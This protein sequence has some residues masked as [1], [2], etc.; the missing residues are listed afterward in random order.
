MKRS[1][2]VSSSR[3][4]SRKAHFTAP[5]SVRRK[6]MSAGLSSELRS[7]YNCRSLPIR[8]DDEVMIVRGLYKNREGKVITCYRKKY[9]IYVD[10][11]VREKATSAKVNVPIHPSNCVIMKL[12]LDKDRKALLERKDRSKEI[13]GKFT[14]EEVAMADV[15]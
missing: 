6:I 14:E 5:S 4:K 9:C 7:K 3:R 13:K 11:V 12:K 2:T 10:N 15:D 8:K 1:S